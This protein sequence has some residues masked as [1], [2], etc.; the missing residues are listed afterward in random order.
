VAGEDVFCLNF[1]IPI[2]LL[3]RQGSSETKDKLER[4]INASIVFRPIFQKLLYTYII[5]AGTDNAYP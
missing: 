5:D 3:S 4:E 2:N 1:S